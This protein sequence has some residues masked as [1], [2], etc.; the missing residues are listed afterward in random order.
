MAAE[1]DLSTGV[2]LVE[3]TPLVREVVEEGRTAY[4]F[5]LT[6]DPADGVGIPAEDAP[7]FL[8]ISNASLDVSYMR[9]GPRPRER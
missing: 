1:A 7:R 9:V 5:L 3:F 4:G 6:L 8:G 2:A